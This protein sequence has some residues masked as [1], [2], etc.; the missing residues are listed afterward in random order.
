MLPTD[1]AALAAGPYRTPGPL[2]ARA[3]IYA[4][5]R[6]PVDLVGAAAAT[7]ADLPAGALVVDAGSGPGRY[8]HRLRPD[9]HRLAVDVS[10]GMLHAIEDGRVLRVVASADTLPLREHAADAALAMHMLYHLPDPQAGLAE[11]RRVVRPGGRLVASTNDETDGLWET[12]R[13]AG[14]PRA[15]VSARWPLAAAP[16]ALRAAGFADVTVQAFDYILDIPAPEP[17]LAYLDSCRAG[18]PDLAD[19]TWTGVRAAVAAAV[20][21]E[22]RRHGALRRTGRVG[23]VTGRQAAGPVGTQ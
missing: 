21:A 16:A 17:V 20:T 10:P 6:P 1:P 19:D 22:I 5:Q 4:W 15:P 13:D 8:L 9:L 7:L 14:L 18:F 23:L 3:A 2:A 11:L 12:F